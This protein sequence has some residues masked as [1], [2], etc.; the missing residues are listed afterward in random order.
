M[1]LQNPGDKLAFLIDAGRVDLLESDEDIPE[2]IF[3]L[4]IQRRRPLVRNLVNFRQKQI[5]TGQ[6]RKQRW[7]YLRGLR[8]WHR[9]VKGKRFHRA[10]GRYLAT[11]IFRPKLSTF[12]DRFENLDPLQ[13]KA[14]KAISSTRTHLYLELGYYQSI[15]EEADLFQLLEYAIPLLNNIEVK[16]FHD[17]NADLS[18]DELELLVRL[19]DENELCKSFSDLLDLEKEPVSETF[20][21]VYSM[22][23]KNSS[24]DDTLFYTTKVMEKFSDALVRL[25]KKK[26]MEEGD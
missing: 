7:K 13:D 5:Q 3:E 10:M 6:W 2:E 21:A 8:K 15:E 16:L 4:F 14:L 25:L 19:V 1:K 26:T 24:K 23:V 18:E 9:S 20:K 11:R 12:A 17:S 22:S